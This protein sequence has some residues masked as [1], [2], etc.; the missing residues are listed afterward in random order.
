[1]SID[2]HLTIENCKVSSK[3]HHPDLSTPEENDVSF[4][5]TL[6]SGVGMREKFE[7]RYRLGMAHL[8]ERFPL[9]YKTLRKLG[10]P[11]PYDSFFS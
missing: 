10:L 7:I 1:M 9:V 5:R 3:G 6:L 11:K 8:C 2:D 4:D